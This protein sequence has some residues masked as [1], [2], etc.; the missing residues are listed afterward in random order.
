MTRISQ[1]ECRGI[2]ELSIPYST[3][4][5]VNKKRLFQTLLNTDVSFS[6][7]PQAS[8][9]A[10]CIIHAVFHG[11]HFLNR[12][13]FEYRHLHLNADPE[14]RIDAKHQEGDTGY[15]P[16]HHALGRIGGDVQYHVYS[17][18]NADAR[19]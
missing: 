18:R 7:S 15:K 2:L 10:N 19:E 13:A 12:H 11:H 8:P 17:A 16:D 5:L 1:Q 4:F 14:E 9:L 6:L 3:L